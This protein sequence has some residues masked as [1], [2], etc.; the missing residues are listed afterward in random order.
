MPATE[1]ASQAMIGITSLLEIETVAGVGNYQEIGEVT[2]LALPNAQVDEIDVT[3]MGS[4]D[5][6]REFISGLTDYGEIAVGMNFVP[7]AAT[8]DDFIDDW[9]EGGNENRSVKITLPNAKVFTF[10]AFVKG[11]ER[12]VPVGDKLESTLTLRVAGAVVRS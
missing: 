4:P 2:S 5:G 11:Y 8:S 6:A 1:V 3:H 7:G 10:P 9:R 12:S